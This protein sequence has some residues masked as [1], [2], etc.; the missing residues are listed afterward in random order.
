MSFL[1]MPFELPGTMSVRK[2]R[3][4][5]L[6]DVIY[7]IYSSVTNF[8]PHSHVVLGT[9]RKQILDVGANQNALKWLRQQQSCGELALGQNWLA[10]FTSP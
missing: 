1:Y 6:A 8:L 4:G 7:A 9:W 10:S 5:R 3:G 2:V